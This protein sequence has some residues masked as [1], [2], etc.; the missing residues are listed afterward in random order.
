MLI[1]SAIF[2]ITA[3]SARSAVSVSDAITTKH[4]TPSSSNS[5]SISMIRLGLLGFFLVPM[6][7]YNRHPLAC[8]KR[9]SAHAVRQG[10]V[11]S[12]DMHNL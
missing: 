5:L 10:V 12:R 8:R 7:T 6:G 11:L 4:F 2:H 3:R 1:V 9:P